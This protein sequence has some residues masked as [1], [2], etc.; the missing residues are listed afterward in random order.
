MDQN[1]EQQTNERRI[2]NQLKELSLDLFGSTSRWQKLKARNVPVKVSRL[3]AEGNQTMVQL[4]DSGAKVFTTTLFTENQ[5]F[6]EL[7]GLKI[8]RDAAMAKAKADR[9]AKEAAMKVQEEAG[10]SVNL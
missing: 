7:M 9:D 4:Y 8:E 5:I 6:E 2:R 10:G 1:N 3:D